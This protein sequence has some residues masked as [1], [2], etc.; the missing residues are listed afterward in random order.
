MLGSKGTG[1]AESLRSPIW[2]KTGNVRKNV[3]NCPLRGLNLDGAH[4]TDAGLERLNVPGAK[5]SA[6]RRLVDLIGFDYFGHVA[7][8]GLPWNAKVGDSVVE[9]VGRLTQL[10][11]LNIQFSDPSGRPGLTPPGYMM[12]PRFGGSGKLV[13]TRYVLPPGALRRRAV[14]M[15]SPRFG[16]SEE[17]SCWSFVAGWAGWFAAL[18]IRRDAATA[19]Q[20][21][22]GLSN[23]ELL[24]VSLKWFSEG[25]PSEPLVPIKRLS[26]SALTSDR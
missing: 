7:A 5:P 14:I 1:I 15:I 6:S 19:L 26:F 24:T 2:R 11:K 12:S 13:S 25:G 9:Q 17:S 18:D 8:V 23:L 3:W 20:K 4:V 16:G 10:Q 21:A 22:L